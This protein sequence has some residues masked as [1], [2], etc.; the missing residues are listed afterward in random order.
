MANTLSSVINTKY[1]KELQRRLE[2]QL[3]WLKLWNS[4]LMSQMPD[5]NTITV[6]R[7]NYQETGQY[8][9]YTDVNVK[10]IKTEDETLVINKHPYISFEIDLEDEQDVS[11]DII[12]KMIERSAYQLNSEIDGDFFNEYV[13]AEYSNITPVALTPWNTFSTYGKAYATLLNNNVNPWAIW[14]VVS[15]L[16]VQKIAEATQGNTFT[17]ADYAFKNGDTGQTFQGM[18]VFVSTNLTAE[19]ALNLATN[20]TANDTVT[21]NGVVFKFVTSLS[22][23]G[24]VKIWANAAASR[25]NLIA[26]INWTGTAW[27]DYIDFTDSTR[28]NKLSGISVVEEWTTVK[29]TSKRGYKVV[30]S[31]LTAPTDSW[32]AIVI[33]NIVMEKGA[34]D[35]VI[36]NEVMTKVE[37]IQKQLWTRVI[38]HT[39]YGIK[40]FKDGAERMYDLRIIAQDA[41]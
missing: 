6:P 20:P 18:R 39:R 8:I 11:Y 4:R 35:F 41:E 36:R 25:A 23:E 14:L 10:D 15:P 19:W 31:N 12:N 13:N 24:D 17:F 34:I 33:H 21:I 22:N 9:K 27:T 26:A 37:S 28:A 38:T 40:T 7:L 1:S 32:G 29:L 16:E 2:A 3:V 5:G 30:S